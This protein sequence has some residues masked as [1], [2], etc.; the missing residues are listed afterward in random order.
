[1]NEQIKN[2]L[3][4]LQNATSGL[5]KLCDL[6]QAKLDYFNEEDRRKINEFNETFE[7]KR[8]QI[9]LKISSFVRFIEKSF[10]P[11]AEEI[12][13]EKALQKLHTDFPEFDKWDASVQ[14][15]ILEREMKSFEVHAKEI[16]TKEKKP[17][18][19]SAVSV[20]NPEPDMAFPVTYN[21]DFCRPYAIEIC[22]E[23]RDITSWRDALCQVADVVCCDN[24]SLLT[25]FIAQDVSKRPWFSLTPSTYRS[26][27][28]MTNGI[29][30]EANLNARDM[31]KSCRKLL[32]IYGVNYDN[33][34]IYLSKI[35]SN[36]NVQD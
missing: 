32:D 22:G 8:E 33:V 29:Y 36:G 1:M 23:R 30:T 21:F 18:L 25:N 2:I 3:R 16:K 27:L 19:G 9:D 7:Q 13:K 34:N 28:E 15:A 11:S 26:P 4:D 35:S 5:N 20:D 6:F 24:Q 12:V 10:A 17:T 14:N 31:L